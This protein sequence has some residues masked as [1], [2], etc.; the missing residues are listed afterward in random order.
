MKTTVATRTLIGPRDENQDR[1]Y[2]ESAESGAWAVAV[3]D[4]LGGHARGAE[5]AQAA[6]DQMRPEVER[7][8]MLDLFAA[9]DA[10]VTRLCK[11]QR[12]FSMDWRKVPMT[13]LCIAVFHPQHA[14][15]VLVGWA[16]D[17][18]AYKLKNDGG[19]LRAFRVGVPH[20][21]HDGTISRCL[22]LDGIPEAEAVLVDSFTGIAVCS[23][24]AWD[25]LA[26]NTK[27]D[28]YCD[29]FEMPLGCG[30]EADEV[31][32]LLLSAADGLGLNDNAT[33][34]VACW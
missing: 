20:N 12:G 7:S 17:T 24:G 15:E 22:G 18:M 2:A 33:V 6:V 29:Y 4:G 30:W 11:E 1:G 14:S 16:G 21:N 23:D 5:A 25:P 34:A 26:K 27:Y 3:A 9:A 28:H 19:V 13:T 31:A 8:E 32:D 10:D